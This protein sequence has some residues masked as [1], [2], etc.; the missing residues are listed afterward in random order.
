MYD[1][2]FGN[3]AHPLNSEELDRILHELGINVPDELK[4]HYLAF[5]GGSPKKCLFNDGETIYVVQEFLPVKYAPPGFR[6]E[7]V[8][9]DL[10]QERKVFPE[11]LIPFAND[12][13]GDYFC[14][15]NDSQNRGSIYI[16]RSETAYHYPDRAVKFLADSLHDF[17][18]QLEAEPD[19]IGP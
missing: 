12:P 15:S 13:G 2:E 1:N 16:F 3:T 19:R 14:I 6:F 4:R 10:K 17:I 7:D 8:V 5:N 11:H 9:R 18:T